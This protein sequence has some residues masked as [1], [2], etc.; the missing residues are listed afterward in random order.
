[1]RVEALPFLFT[2]TERR[3][4]IFLLCTSYVIPTY[5]KSGHGIPRYVCYHTMPFRRNNSYHK[6]CK[7]GSFIFSCWKKRN[8]MGRHASPQKI[9]TY[10]LMSDQCWIFCYTLSVGENY[11]L[12]LTITITYSAVFGQHEGTTNHPRK[13]LTHT[14]HYDI[15]NSCERYDE[16]RLNRAPALSKFGR[17]KLRLVLP[18]YI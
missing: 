5:T 13:R 11:I 14:I 9:T 17:K 4:R 3:Q 8:S 10:V 1:M 6:A 12:I 7:F 2:E 15:K 18:Q 16:N